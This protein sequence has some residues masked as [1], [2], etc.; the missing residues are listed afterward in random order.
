MLEADANYGDPDG[1]LYGNVVLQDF[2]IVYKSPEQSGT[3][4]G[5]YEVVFNHD[6]LTRKKADGS[7]E[8]SREAGAAL[9]NRQDALKF[10]L[11][12]LANQTYFKLNN[13]Y[14]PDP[15]SGAS[16][17]GFKKGDSIPLPME[18]QLM[19]ELGGVK[20]DD[21]KAV[22][23]AYYTFRGDGLNLR[24]KGGTAK[25]TNIQYSP[26][27]NPFAFEIESKLMKD[28]I[29]SALTDEIKSRSDQAD[30]LTRREGNAD[31][32]TE[33]ARLKEEVE[34][35]ETQIDKLTEQRKKFSKAKASFIIDRDN[36]YFG[37]EIFQAG[38]AQD[39]PSF[40]EVL[41]SLSQDE[42]ALMVAIDK[43]Q[44]GTLFT[45][46]SEEDS[47]PSQGGGLMSGFNTT[48]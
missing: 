44:G 7:N 41:L 24:Y 37:S 33:R 28:D 17:S 27:G 46:D 36:Q 35:L 9:K 2:N 31:D 20:G 18:K 21:G 29:R 45:E 42:R 40:I 47:V 23:G 39:I 5:E 6:P 8:F 11:E 48:E 38:T 32:V 22:K 43:Q 16:S 10:H 1:R 4:M 3:E 14:Q 26:E 19:T 13:Q 15:Q 12:N 34:E 30:R 25:I